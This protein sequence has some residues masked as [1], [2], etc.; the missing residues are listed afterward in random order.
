MKNQTMK[1]KISTG[2]TFMM[3]LGMLLL[4]NDLMAQES[5]RR[6][7]R[8]SSQSTPP[9][10]NGTTTPSTTGAANPLGEDPTRAEAGDPFNVPGGGLG[11]EMPM[12]EENPDDPF[13]VPGGGLGNEMPMTEENPD[14]PFNVPGGGLGNEMPTTATS[15]SPDDGATNN[16]GGTNAPRRGL[17]GN[18]PA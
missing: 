8:G 10:V 4:L 13:N 18:R 1:N 15:S 3:G 9:T 14:D 17:R 12:T 7:V 16:F 5:T 11:N 2:M 6:V